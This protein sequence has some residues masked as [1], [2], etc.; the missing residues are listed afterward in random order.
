MEI[1]VQQFL[2]FL[3]IFA[4]I[5]ALVVVA[6]FFGHQGVPVQVK[7]GLG[8][9]L[10][11]ILYP[12]ISQHPAPVDLE[13]LPFFVLVLQEVMVGVLL[14]FGLGILFSGIQY[15]GELISFNIG[16]SVATMFSADENQQSPII[17]EFVSLFAMLVFL[18][19]N[20]HHFVLQ[21]LRLTYDTVPIGTFA[22][23][24]PLADHIVGFGSMMFVVAVKIAA[25]VM[26]AE[27]LTNVG[28]SIMAR[29]MPQANVF[30]VSFPLSI[31][32]G[33]IVLFSSAPFMLFV[34]KKLLLGFEDNILELVKVL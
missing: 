9:L 21:A 16:L 2:L 19:L 28:L 23:S 13:L 34:F 10:S 22:F 33:L 7:A 15:A 12:M 30:I 4:R 8:T 31:G 14:G 24:K 6:P 11:F 26:V 20:G 3:V 18:L 32:V 1:Y 5:T 25:P 17:S 29:V 27:F